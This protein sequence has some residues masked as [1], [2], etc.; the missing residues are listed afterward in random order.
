MPKQSSASSNPSPVAIQSVLDVKD[1]NAPPKGAGPLFSQSILILTSERALKFTAVDAE[2][3]YLWLSALSFLAHSQQA[4]PGIL[5]AFVAGPE[6]PGLPNERPLEQ[7]PIRKSRTIRDSIWLTKTKATSGSTQS[8]PNTARP[9]AMSVASSRT[10]DNSASVSASSRSIRTSIPNCRP[11][12]VAEAEEDMHQLPAHMSDMSRDA[13]ESP[14]VPR[15]NPQDVAIRLQSRA[16]RIHERANQVTLHGRRRSNTGGHHE[17]PPLSFLGFASPP[18]HHTAASNSTGIDVAGSSDVYAGHSAGA[19][20]ASSGGLTWATA[21]AR[22]S[23]S[24]SRP[25]F[26]QHNF[27]DAIGTV[28]MEAF[29]SPLTSQRFGE[30]PTMIAGPRGGALLEDERDGDGGRGRHSYQK[31]Q[32]YQ[33]VARRRSKE[34][35]RRASR[36]RI[37]TREHDN[38][39][40]GRAAAGMEEDTVYTDDPFESF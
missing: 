14:N 26:M 37:S 16:Q 24:S 36:N 9:G 31:P 34:A 32:Y 2:K 28:R 4:V 5:P 38:T 11:A 1:D 22:T 25:D 10:T 19:H 35:R 3:H 8:S 6:Q 27:F 17:A 29:I 12:V 13:A 39:P 33:H 21:S 40:F 15:F 20:R 23:V 18:G 30:A 7:S